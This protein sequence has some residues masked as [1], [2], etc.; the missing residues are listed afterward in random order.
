MDATT[1]ASLILFSIEFAWGLLEW[2]WTVPLFDALF[3]G[4]AIGS[5]AILGWL[6]YLWYRRRRWACLSYLALLV[7]SLLLQIWATAQMPPETWDGRVSLVSYSLLDLIA[8]GL[9]LSPS[10]RAWFGTPPASQDAL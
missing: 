8:F 5:V 4:F 10:A 1:V 7:A 6:A 9:L 3:V 2:E